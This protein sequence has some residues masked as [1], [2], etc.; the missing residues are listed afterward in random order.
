MKKSI[1]I[2][3]IGAAVSVAFA[4]SASS[5]M[6]WD[7]P[8]NYTLDTTAAGGTA[9]TSTV[10]AG[11][12]PTVT[13]DV[14]FDATLGWSDPAGSGGNGGVVT[15]TTYSNSSNTPFTTSPTT[16]TSPILPWGL[17]GDAGTGTVKISPYFKVAITGVGYLEVTGSVTGDYTGSAVDFTGAGYASTLTVVASSPGLAAYVGASVDLTGVVPET[18]GTPPSLQ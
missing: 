10:N 3:A 8:G 2:L 18:S 16:V 15:A 6:A 13:S 11:V 14:V 9:L 7:V 4:I 1:R 5:A 17:V 12:N